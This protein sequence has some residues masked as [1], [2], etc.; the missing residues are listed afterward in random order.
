[1][2]DRRLPWL[3]SL[4]LIAT[5]LLA[6][7]LLPGDDRVLAARYTARASFAMF[8][9]LFLATPLARLGWTRA[10][11]AHRRD[12]GLAFALAHFVHLAAL[13]NQ[14]IAAGVPPAVI[15]ITVGGGGYVILAAMA[16]TSNAAAMRALGR[17][18]KWLHRTGLWWL[19]FVFFVTYAGRIAEPPAMIVGI[20]G[21][22]L[23]GG[24]ALL[25]LGL[26]W[27]ARRR[28]PA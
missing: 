28:Q 26:W 4:L 7:T 8:M 3:L 14:Q 27:R 16:L 18:W 1:M 17:R 5:A 11:A 10:L 19:W 22:G 13:I 25:R 20:I 24:A 15:T 23:A 12:W 21:T 6:A 2:A 9:P